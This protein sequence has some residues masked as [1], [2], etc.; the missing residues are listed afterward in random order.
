VAT[1]NVLGRVTENPSF[2]Y[3]EVTVLMKGHV[4]AQNTGRVILARGVK[5]AKSSA[6]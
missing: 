1:T 6:G 3:Y 5:D 4:T 2:R